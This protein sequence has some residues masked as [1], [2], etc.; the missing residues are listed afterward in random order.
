MQASNKNVIGISGVA[1]A[2]K[3]TFAAILESKLKATGK[4]VCKIALADPLKSHCNSFLK[5]HLGISAFTQVPEEKS[6]IRPMLVWYGDAQ[7]KKTN[8]RYWVD[9]ASNI[10]NETEYD[11]YIITDIR[12]SEYKEDELFWLKN[13][14]NGTLCH[15]SKYFIM[16]RGEWEFVQPAND[17]EAANDPKINQAAHYRVEW[18]HIKCNSPEDLLLNKDMNEHVKKFM[19]ACLY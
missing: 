16:P 12:Y 4:S 19:E 6:L 14:W 8:G 10:I 18:E 1:R 9:L 7:R 17:H 11:Y 3:D 13:E 15:I 5:E 2:G